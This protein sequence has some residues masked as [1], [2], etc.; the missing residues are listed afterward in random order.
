MKLIVQKSG[1][2]DLKLEDNAS[3][4]NLNQFLEAE[5]QDD[6]T[7]TFYAIVGQ[8][9]SILSKRNVAES[10]YVIHSDIL[11][12]ADEGK[13]QALIKKHNT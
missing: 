4:I 5:A 12:K 10:S 9:K 7:Q 1:A 2:V 13:Y 6:L 11:V 8:S 3:G